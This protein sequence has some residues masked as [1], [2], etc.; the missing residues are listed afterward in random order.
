LLSFKHAK[1]AFFSV[2]AALIVVSCV[3]SNTK[4]TEA[5]R[6]PASIAILDWR[7]FLNRIDKPNIKKIEEALKVL[8]S[9]FSEYMSFHTLAYKSRSIQTSSYLFPR[10]IVFGP[11]AKFV[12]TFNGSPKNDHYNALEV[13]QFD[14]RTLKYELRAV[15]FKNEPGPIDL[16]K[17]DIESETTNLV[18]SK[19]N[20]GF[21]LGCHGNA[22]DDSHPIIQGYHFWPGMYGSDNDAV[23]YRNT[24]AYPRFL[25][26]EMN[27]KENKN[28]AL[29]NKPENRKKGRYKF[30]P[31]MNKGITGLLADSYFPPIRSAKELQTYHSSLPEPNAFL[32]N[33]FHRQVKRQI[34]S[35]IV[36]SR[37]G[38][39]LGLGL[40]AA[41]ACFTTD[42]SASAYLNQHQK[43]FNEVIP[44]RL[45]RKLNPF[46]I[47]E[48][49]YSSFF[50][51]YS[52]Q[53]ESNLIYDMIFMDEQEDGKLQLRA[54]DLTA[55]DL[56][57]EIRQSSLAR[58]EKVS[59][60]FAKAALNFQDSVGTMSPLIDRFLFAA[61]GSH[62]SEYATTLQHS[63]SL[64]DGRAS[65]SSLF[66]EILALLLTKNLKAEWATV[67]RQVSEGDSDAYGAVASS[68]CPSLIQT[69]QKALNEDPNL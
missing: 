25:L 62:I 37:S 23:F 27:S 44:A 8:N 31:P 45:T 47:T 3:S 42:E 56:S 55:A 13:I 54:S 7:T 10:A 38:V 50:K 69:A 68:D 40:I 52:E 51:M 26:A 11:E 28:W 66:N 67:L 5:P 59:P 46:P 61:N 12:F 16:P 63:A 49:S 58:M 9:E 64:H 39:A 43:I 20:P 4:T 6:V 22:N 33:L 35:A 30:L 17:E 2:L 34:A 18:I 1:I 53:A 24:S 19:P 21:C 29:F 60:K 41:K 15:V 57:D 36:E 14:E 65:E 48:N 32:T